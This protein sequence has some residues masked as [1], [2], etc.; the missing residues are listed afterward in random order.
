MRVGMVACRDRAPAAVWR[1][2]SS[3]PRAAT[4]IL[5]HIVQNEHTCSP[6]PI[7]RRRTAAEGK[8]HRVRQERLVT[9]MTPNGANNP[10]RH[11]A[12]RSAAPGGG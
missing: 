6:P 7:V 1:R 9:A 8:S 11:S 12:Q 4:T 2:S 5:L 10:L 3:G